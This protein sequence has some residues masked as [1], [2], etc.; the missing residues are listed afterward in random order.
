MQELESSI[1]FFHSQ[2]SRAM[3]LVT[4]VVG[5]VVIA[6]P[7]SPLA[8]IL[9]LKPPGWQLLGLI[10]GVVLLYFVSAELVKRWFF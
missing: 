5:I 2:P 6:L 1:N 10:F 8:A 9:E 4:L 3:M 7:Y